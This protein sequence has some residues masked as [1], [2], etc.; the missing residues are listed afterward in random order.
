MPK[1][2]AVKLKL[3]VCDVCD[4]VDGLEVAAVNV[5][6]EPQFKAAL[7]QIRKF[8]EVEL[9]R[10]TGIMMSDTVRCETSYGPHK[11]NSVTSR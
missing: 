3:D 2:P 10:Q 11:C 1:C 9:K 6:K 7:S 4:I 8:V 5:Q